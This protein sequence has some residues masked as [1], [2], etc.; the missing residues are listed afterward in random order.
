MVKKSQKIVIS[1][2]YGIC[3]FE[4]FYEVK[5]SSPTEEFP[6]FKKIF[7]DHFSIIFRPKT[8]FLDTDSVL[9]VTMTYESVK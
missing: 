4:P 3:D 6:N 9:R 7:Q 1:I 5:E 2:K 8:V